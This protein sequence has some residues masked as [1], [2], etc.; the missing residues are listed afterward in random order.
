MTDARMS[1]AEGCS[2][3]LIVSRMIAFLRIV[4]VRSFNAAKTSELSGTAGAGSGFGASGAGSA[5]AGDGASAAASGATMEGSEVGPM[6]VMISS[7]VKPA[8]TS[9]RMSLISM[10]VLLCLFQFFE[11]VALVESGS[12]VTAPEAYPKGIRA[13]FVYI[14]DVAHPSEAVSSSA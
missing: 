12:G 6:S 1:T 4:C 14:L 7:R 9:E 3:G 11:C 2:V 13:I 5:A 8:F 10:F